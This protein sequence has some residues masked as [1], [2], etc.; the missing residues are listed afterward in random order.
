MRVA[1]FWSPHLRISQP[2]DAAQLWYEA[3]LKAILM[4][5]MATIAFW[6]HSSTNSVP[7]SKSLRGKPMTTSVRPIQIRNYLP[8]GT[9]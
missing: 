2:L 7:E 5:K 1:R 9:S 6:K 3:A 4:Q 8:F